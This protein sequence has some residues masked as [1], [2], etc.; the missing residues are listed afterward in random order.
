M[1]YTQLAMLGIVAV[2]S[3]LLEWVTRNHPSHW[4]AMGEA[5]VVAM[6]NGEPRVL[7]RLRV[8]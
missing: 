7:A 1:S 6:R 4:Q 8:E 3:S 5:V 2:V